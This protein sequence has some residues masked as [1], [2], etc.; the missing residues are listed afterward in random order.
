[1]LGYGTDNILGEIRYENVDFD[2][3]QLRSETGPPLFN[4]YN[5]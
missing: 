2:L 4:Q 1:M 5:N 3:A